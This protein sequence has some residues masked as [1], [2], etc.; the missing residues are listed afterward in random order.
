MFPEIQNAPFITMERFDLYVAVQFSFPNRLF[1][2]FGELVGAAG[3]FVPAGYAFQAA[4]YFLRRHAL[5]QKF[6]AT[7]VA[8]A[9][10]NKFYLPDDAAFNFHVDSGGTGSVRFI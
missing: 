4:D 8:W 10:V 9:A 1:Q 5:H 7:G 2:C 6:N 3:G